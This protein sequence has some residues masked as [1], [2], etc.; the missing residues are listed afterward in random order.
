MKNPGTTYI[1]LSCIFCTIIVTGNLIFQKFVGIDFFGI[2]FEISVGAFLFPLTFLISDL[3]TEFYGKRMALQMINAAVI[4]SFV[5]FAL[6]VVSD[7][8]SATSWSRVDDATFSL[9]FSAFGLSAF[10]SVIANYLAQV[11]EVNTFSY[12]KK[13]TLGRHLWL[14]NNVSTII[15]QLVDSFMVAAIGSSVGIV[16]WEQFFVLVYSSFGFKVVAALL[17]TPFCY[18]GFYLMQRSTGG[19]QES[20]EPA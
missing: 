1:Y 15:G 9:V 17:D 19:Q 13:L 7:S 16:P 20:L 3:V 4:C 12:L 6:V 14:R 11:V 18:L 5:V 2:S 8:L 10:G